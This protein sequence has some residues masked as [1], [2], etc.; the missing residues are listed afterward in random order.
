MKHLKSYLSVRL[1]R[2]RRWRSK[3]EEQ[4][5]SNNKYN[6]SK[7]SAVLV[8]QWTVF[9]IFRLRRCIKKQKKNLK[10]LYKLW[11]L[12]VKISKRFKRCIRMMTILTCLH[13]IAPLC[14]NLIRR[15]RKDR[16]FIVEI[17]NA[18]MCIK[19]LSLNSVQNC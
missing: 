17:R 10:R 3:R 4:T 7:N 14:K 13:H 18:F 11:W 2:R 15:I 6:K 8:Q 1:W 16:G 19:K 9:S 12:Q 5:R